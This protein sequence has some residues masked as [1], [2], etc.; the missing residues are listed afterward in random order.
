MKG[1]RVFRRLSISTLGA[2]GL[3]LFLVLIF[4]FFQSHEAV[5]VKE[6]PQVISRDGFWEVYFSNPEGPESDTLRGGPDAQLVE[7]MDTAQFSI[8]VAMYHLNLWSVRD[9]LI[10]AH[11]RGVEVRVITDSAYKDELEIL[12]LQEAGIQVVEDRRPSL[13]HH[14][15]VVIDR[16]EVWTGSMNMTLNGAYRNDN[17]LLR[18][19]SKEVAEDYVRE[20]EEMF[21]EDRFGASSLSDTPY[22]ELQ[23]NHQKVEVYFSPED[24]VLKRLLEILGEVDRSVEFLAYALTTDTIGERLLE[25]HRA[26]VKVRGVVEQSQVLATGSETPRLRKAGLDIRLDTNPSSM[27]HKVFI[28]DHEIVLLGSYNFTRS[29]EEKNDE[30]V[31]ILHD[32]ALASQFLLEFERIYQAA[33]P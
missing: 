15:F 4:V 8:D 25:L 30:N 7:A 5:T 9:A 28:V 23:I 31:I 24:Q 32:P 22:P 12:S 17:H 18:L 19:R 27:H 3:L 21:V 33:T 16:D 11:Q 10:Y 1:N 29:A 6:N 14:K 26:G 20:F 2:S 13:M